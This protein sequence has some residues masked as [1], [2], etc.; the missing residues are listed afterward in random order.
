MSSGLLLATSGI[1][2][3]V[4]YQYIQDRRWGMALAFLCYA[5]ANIG[6]AWDASAN[7]APPSEL[8][9]PVL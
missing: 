8:N 7:Q 5:V 1:Y 9:A 2:G 6:F 4:A 3:W